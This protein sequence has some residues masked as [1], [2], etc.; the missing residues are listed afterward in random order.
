MKSFYPKAQD[1]LVKKSWHIIDLKSK[2]LGRITTEIA[3]ILMGKNK[4]TFTPGADTG[5]FVIAINSDQIKL[6]GRKWEQKIYYRHTGFMGG[7]RETTAQKQLEKDSTKIVLQAVKGMLPKN[8]FGR[9]LLGKL[10]VY[11]NEVHP[12]GA[13]KPQALSLAS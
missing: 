13:Q 11:K 7:I 10:K 6:T 9:K 4:P 2:S 12:H 3:R 5:D 8:I 1:E